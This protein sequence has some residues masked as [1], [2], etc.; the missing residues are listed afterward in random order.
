MAPGFYVPEVCL[1][2]RYQV[3]NKCGEQRLEQ[4]L[5]IMLWEPC[6]EVEINPELIDCISLPW[7]FK[8]DIL[9]RNWR[10][11]GTLMKSLKL[12]K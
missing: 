12:L 10:V 9:Y 3:V 5:Q 4:H 8:I 2:V 11:H 7:Q 6:L 1:E